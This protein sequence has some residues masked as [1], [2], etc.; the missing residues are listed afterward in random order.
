MSEPVLRV[1]AKAILVNGEGDILMLR[2]AKTYDEG[3]NTGRYHAPGGR[4][5]PNESYTD[6]LK[7]EVKEETGI[8]DVAIGEPVYVGEWWPVIKGVP[9]H[10]V[11]IFSVCRTK[12]R[13]VV[14]SNEHDAFAWVG[15]KDIANYDIMAP[16]P[17]AIA[18]Y[19]DRFAT[20]A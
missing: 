20:A 2:E 12:V 14:L 19:L 4:M 5:E 6:A 8:T 7:R 11:A 3:T 10:I 1:A 13:D 17:E 15:P 18:A 16:E 9:H